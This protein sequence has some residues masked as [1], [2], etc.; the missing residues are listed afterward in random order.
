M[1][2]L[3]EDDLYANGKKK[4]CPAFGS[5]ALTFSLE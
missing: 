4:G 2:I 1:G 5:Y 3:K